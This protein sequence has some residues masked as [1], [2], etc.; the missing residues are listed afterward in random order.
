[1]GGCRGACRQANKALDLARVKHTAMNIG[2]NC[3]PKVSDPGRM[4]LGVSVY[5][6]LVLSYYFIQVHLFSIHLC[7]FISITHPSQPGESCPVKHQGCN[8]APHFPAIPYHMSGI[9][10]GQ[11]A[12]A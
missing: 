8:A 12:S 1:M 2:I 11:S 3:E 10:L 9:G 7:I 5:K 6:C 4:S